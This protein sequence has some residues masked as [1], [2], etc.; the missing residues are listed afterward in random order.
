MGSEVS[1]HNEKVNFS[2]GSVKVKPKLNAN[3]IPLPGVG[4]KPFR[5]GGWFPKSFCPECGHLGLVKGNCRKA[6]CPDCSTTWRY[7]RT[8]SIMERLLSYKLDREIGNG[9][10][11]TINGKEEN[12]HVRTRIRHFVISPSEERIEQ[13]EDIEDITGR[14]VQVI[15]KNGNRYSK[16][17]QPGLFQW[18]YEFAEE[19]NVDGGLMIFHPYRLKVAKE[20]KDLCTDND[21]DYLCDKCE[22]TDECPLLQL[23]DIASDKDNWQPG[24]FHLWRTLVTLDD[25]HRYVEWSP[26]FHV[27]VVGE[28]FDEGGKEGDGGDNW[29]GVSELSDAEA[30]LKCSMYLLSHTGLISEVSE[31]NVQAV[32][33]FGEMSPAKW[34]IRKA[35]PAVRHAVH[36]KINGLL[37]GFAKDVGECSNR[38]ECPVCGAP[39]EDMLNAPEYVDCFE[40]EKRR[41]LSCA[42]MWYLT[43]KS[44]PADYTEEEVKAWMIERF[45]IVP[46]VDI[47]MRDYRTGR[48]P[49]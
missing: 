1:C 14:Y 11:V 43:G 28:W 29:I 36:Q 31:R 27:L 2:R 33:W 21:G 15:S 35:S 32:R 30:V 13:L 45:A 34:S 37:K 40:A 10:P 38:Y 19:H 4:P 16:L 41:V 42:F 23:R 6:I 12:V 18:A 9:V 25:W 39:L 7:D 44:P 49:G 26:H 20:D 17:E 5:C 22:F 48:Y 24:N 8:R 47:Y 46:D 3:I